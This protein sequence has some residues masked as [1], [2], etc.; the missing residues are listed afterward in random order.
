MRNKLQGS[1]PT[2]PSILKIRQ[3][4]VDRIAH[5]SQPVDPQI[6]QKAIDIRQKAIDAGVSIAKTEADL[7]KMSA[8]HLNAFIYA[9]RKW[10]HDKKGV[11]LR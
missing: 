9:T 1:F 8:K 11:I 3:N 2:D 10:A 7:H 5:D 4:I 6:L